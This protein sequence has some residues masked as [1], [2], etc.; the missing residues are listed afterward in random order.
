MVY[1]MGDG[2]GVDGN[3]TRGL[4]D[5]HIGARSLHVCVCTF[6][7]VDRGLPCVRVCVHVYVHRSFMC[8]YMS[9]CMHTGSVCVYIC[10]Y[11][12]CVRVHISVIT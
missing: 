8:V 12:S 3:F 7:Y 2:R 5:L 4:A 6:T 1:A 11:I 10:I 9:T